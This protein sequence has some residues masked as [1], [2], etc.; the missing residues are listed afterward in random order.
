MS[1]VSEFGKFLRKL[2]VDLDEPT[3]AMAKKIGI[4]LA[5]LSA[6]EH[7]RCPIPT[8]W[9]P[10]IISAY[11]LNTEQQRVLRAAA[12]SQR[13]LIKIGVS[14][15]SEDVRQFVGRLAEELGKQ[16]YVSNDSLKRIID[17]ISA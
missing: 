5:Y 10:R 6:A 1:K 14:H 16:K 11:K 17:H 2:R 8:K 15:C 7:G 13:A 12:L 3:A 9:I 4:S